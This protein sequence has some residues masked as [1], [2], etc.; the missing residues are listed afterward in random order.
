MMCKGGG[1][2]PHGL[3]IAGGGRRLVLRWRRLPHGR[4]RGL[5]LKGRRLHGMVLMFHFHCF[6]PL[7]GISCKPGHTRK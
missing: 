3:R 4:L 5:L 1:D 7:V 2:G 6:A